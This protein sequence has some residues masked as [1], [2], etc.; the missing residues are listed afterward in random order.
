MLTRGPRDLQ[1]IFSGRVLKNEDPITKYGIKQGV[2]I[3]LVRWHSPSD[4]SVGRH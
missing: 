4:R 3:H 2:A 1:L